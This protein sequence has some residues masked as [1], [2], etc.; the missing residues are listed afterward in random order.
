MSGRAGRRGARWA[1]WM[2]LAT[3]GTLQGAAPCVAQPTGTDAPAAAPVPFSR[4]QLDQLTAPIALYPDALLGQIL[5]AATYPLEVV[6]AHRWLL[7]A[8]NA[9][10]RGDALLAA[11][12]RQ[13]WDTS[14]KALVPF[15]AVLAMMDDHLDWTELLGDAFLSEQAALM[16]SIQRLR[17]RAAA[18]G[19]LAST[20]QQ[21]VTTVGPD[22]EIEPAV[23]DDAYVPYYD[24]STV[25]GSWPWPDDPPFYFPLPPGTDITLGASVV[26][27]GPPV[28]LL[29]PLWNWPHWRWR[30]HL[31]EVRRPEDPAVA[32]PWHHDPRHRLG[33][34][35]RTAALTARY[36]ALSQAGRRA[37]ALSPAHLPAGSV[38]PWQLGTRQLVRP[39]RDRGSGAFTPGLPLAERPSEG[40]QAPERGARGA[41]PLHRPMGRAAPAREAAPAHQSS[42][43][44]SPSPSSPAAPGAHGAGRP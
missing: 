29:G 28:P 42:A 39:S 44:Q 11:L 6:E 38:P 8:A 10:L 30:R 37:Q 15:G 40:F 2:A 7:E 1:L 19:S 27:F 26:G 35:Y 20:P 25:Y 17:R 12:Q 34:P 36:E 3:L 31:L 41:E 16:D 21:N 43:A 22:I 23:A 5:V 33:V 14:V 9:A 24:P 13:P 18:G 32:H 4:A